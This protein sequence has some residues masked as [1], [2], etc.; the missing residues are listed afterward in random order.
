MRTK[1][2]H[3][4]PFAL[5][6]YSRWKRKW[7]AGQQWALNGV[8]FE[9]FFL[10]H[11]PKSHWF[12]APDTSEFPICQQFPVSRTVVSRS[13]PEHVRAL[14]QIQIK[15]KFFTDIGTCAS[16]G[17]SLPPLFNWNGA[18]ICSF[19]SEQGKKS[20]FSSRFTGLCVGQHEHRTRV[21][22][23]SAN[24]IKIPEQSIRLGE[25]AAAPIYTNREIA[26]FRIRMNPNGN[27]RE[28]RNNN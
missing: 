6:M 22:V 10:L 4:C 7:I 12:N 2:A 1:S 21:Y 24:V 13:K 5:N 19:T 8:L 15:I 20:V 23:F 28:H 11:G 17:Q 14:R 25:R 3:F 27:A 26:W 16:G 9:V 18:Y